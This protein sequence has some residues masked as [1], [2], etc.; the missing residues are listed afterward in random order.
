MTKT[1]GDIRTEC[2]RNLKALVV[3]T[4]KDSSIESSLKRGLQRLGGFDVENGET[5]VIKPNLTTAK[6]SPNSGVTTP[7]DVVE[8]LIKYINGLKRECHIFIVESDSDGRIEET[9]QALGYE[10]LAN[11][12][13]NVDLV[14][15]GR[16]KIFKVV[17]P[18]FCKARLIEVPEILLEMNKFIN[19][20]NL[21]RHILEGFTGIWKN[22]YGLPSNHLVRMKFHPFLKELLFDLNYLF[23]PDLSV[24]DARIGLGG[25]GP[26]SGSP[27]IY[28][29][30]V[31]SLNPIAADLASLRIIDEKVRR[32]PYLHYAAR[33]LKVNPADVEIAGDRWEPKYLPF[34]S[35]I[36]FRIGRLS[37]WIRRISIY[38]ENLFILGWIA[39][40]SVS[41]GGVKQF[42]SGGIQTLGTSI[43]MAW[44]LLYKIDLGKQI[45]G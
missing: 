40:K 45:H 37:M 33:K 19:V 7:V 29:K 25:K 14:D 6:S 17:M 32:V 27:S 44:K 36:Q 35:A 28:N 12:Y 11:N 39:G 23:W 2:K 26:L 3:D 16:Q 10:E 20:A 9:F 13:R 38:A 24:V 43:R 15:L 42:S 5:V 18:T 34:V 4:E 22:A 31:I 21:K 41:M 8:S 30:L 1:L